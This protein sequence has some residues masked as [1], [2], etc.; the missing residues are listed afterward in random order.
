MLLAG[1][2][3]KGGDFRAWREPLIGKG[4]ALLLFGQDAKKIASDLAGLD[5]HIVMRDVG[6]LDQ[7][8]LAADQLACAGD[9]VLLSPG[10]ASF[11]Q[12]Q[13]YAERG[14][15]FAELARGLA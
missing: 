4:R 2:Q 11:D 5:Q 14:E 9:S 7:A 10:C 12:F 1:G 8:V 6:E 15:R 3:A 13:G